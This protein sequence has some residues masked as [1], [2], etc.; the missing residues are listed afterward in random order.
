MVYKINNTL[1]VTIL[2]LVQTIFKGCFYLCQNVIS[3][4]GNS[5]KKFILPE[6][7]QGLKIS[8]LKF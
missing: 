8:E 4:K 6:N 7:H 1:L 2:T 3:F 5:K